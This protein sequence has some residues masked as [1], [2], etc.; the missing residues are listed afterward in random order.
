MVGD[1]LRDRIAKSGVASAASCINTWQYFRKLA[2][3]ADS[4]MVPVYPVTPRSLVLVGALSKKGGYRK[5][6]NYLSAAKAAY[7]EE[8]FEWGQLLAH[9]AGWGTRS[10]LRGIGPARQSCSFRVARL[11]QLARSSAAIVLDGPQAPVHLA[12]FATIFLLREV[13]GSTAVFSA[14]E[15]DEVDL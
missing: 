6:P 13:E 2:F 1:L 3:A 12:L 11:C 14:W 10:V 7:I 5:F 15:M 4:P 8:R 9:T